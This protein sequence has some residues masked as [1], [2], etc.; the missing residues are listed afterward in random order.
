MVFLLKFANST[1]LIV[2][3]EGEEDDD[4]AA[5]A[6]LAGEH[7]RGAA[8]LLYEPEEGNDDEIPAAESSAAGAARGAGGAPA[9]GI[10][11]IF[12]GFVGGVR[13]LSDEEQRAAAARVDELCEVIGGALAC[14][15]KEALGIPY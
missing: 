14:L 5:A 9:S 8:A 6:Q 10:L 15:A 4:F 12:G 7:L 11:G 1:A 2:E 3:V 13:S